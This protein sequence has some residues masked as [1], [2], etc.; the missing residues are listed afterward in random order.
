MYEE[1]EK[2]LKEARKVAKE[3]RQEVRKVQAELA[4]INKALDAYEAFLFKGE[5]PRYTKQK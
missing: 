5:K 2:Q 4:E 1:F 3:V